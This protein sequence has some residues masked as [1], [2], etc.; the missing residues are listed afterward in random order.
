[1]RRS[2]A[3]QY[4]EEKREKK[5]KLTLTIEKLQPASKHCSNVLAN[6]C[7]LYLFI[8]FHFLPIIYVFLCLAF[9]CEH[10]QFSYRYL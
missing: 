3:K 2:F 4:E 7:C 9:A 6:F 5:Q 10:R 1:M 8:Y